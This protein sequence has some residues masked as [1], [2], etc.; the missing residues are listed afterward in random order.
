[1]ATSNSAS[2]CITVTYVGRLNNL[3][4]D[5]GLEMTPGRDDKPHLFE[6][7]P[8]RLSQRLLRRWNRLRSLYYD[9]IRL[10]SRE[11]P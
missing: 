11:L 9:I 1:M 2:E 6:P 3:G 8:L 4:C 5:W 10:H 7:G